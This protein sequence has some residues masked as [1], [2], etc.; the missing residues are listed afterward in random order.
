MPLIQSRPLRARY[1]TP[2]PNLIYTPYIDIKTLS[3]YRVLYTRLF[4][5]ATS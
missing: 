4:L 2:P 5:Q 3:R 1:Y